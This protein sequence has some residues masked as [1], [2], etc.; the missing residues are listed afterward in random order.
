MHI[1]PLRP[2]PFIYFIDRIN[3]N[4]DQGRHLPVSFFLFLFKNILSYHFLFPHKILFI[5]LFL[6]YNYKTARKYNDKIVLWFIILV[7]E[8]LLSYF[9][10]FVRNIS[11]KICSFYLNLIQQMV[12]CVLDIITGHFL[13]LL[14]LVTDAYNIYTFLC[15]FHDLSRFVGRRVQA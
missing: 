3:E 1:F 6:I 7:Y 4:D 11:N 12:Y 10:I 13:M 9:V 15:F 14:T 2:K 5:P 8:I